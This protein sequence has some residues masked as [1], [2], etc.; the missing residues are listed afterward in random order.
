MAKVPPP[1]ASAPSRIRFIMVEAEI[2]DSGDLTQITQ[3][4]QN[5]LRPA[6][7]A[8]RL[9]SPAAVKI[10]GTGTPAPV[11]LEAEEEMELGEE[12]VAEPVEPSRP[13]PSTRVRKFKS[14]EVVQDLDLTSEPTFG[15]FIA[16]KNAESH[17]M[18]FLTAAAWL[19]QHRQIEAV[20]M[21][22][23]YTCYRNVKW[24][25]DVQDFSQPL[26]DLKARDFL[27]QKE[28]GHYAINHLGL[29]E[30]DNLVKP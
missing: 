28:R 27:V 29:Q 19:K 10:N 14:P 23:I 25:T 26:R 4:I 16:D 1:K 30:V 24:S 21:N 13:A 3:A 7:A 20:N 6:T 12:T 22:Y 2:S 11:T 9:S 17:Q 15:Q 18:K 8:P 5:A